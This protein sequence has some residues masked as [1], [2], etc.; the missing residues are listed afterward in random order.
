MLEANAALPSL[1]RAASSH[2]TSPSMPHTSIGSAEVVLTSAN[3][4]TPTPRRL[5]YVAA[6]TTMGA[7]PCSP[8]LRAGGGGAA[9]RANIMQLFAWSQSSAQQFTILAIDRCG[10][11]GLIHVSMLVSQTAGSA[12]SAG[13][14]L[15]QS[16]LV[17]ASAANRTHAWVAFNGNGSGSA[18]RSR[19]G[20][21]S[22]EASGEVLETAAPSE[23]ILLPF[24]SRIAPGTV[25][26]RLPPLLHVQLLPNTPTHH[27]AEKT[28]RRILEDSTLR[29]TALRHGR[30]LAAAM[31]R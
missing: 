11:G 5:A 20:V 1:H 15:V 3:R 12:N 8:Q 14:R 16:Q 13:K 25:G 7:V 21:P 24:V 22:D 2:A 27:A 17:A 4:V 18:D 31:R 10:A 9:L 6:S 23:P 26:V 28:I 29:C 19:P 30:T